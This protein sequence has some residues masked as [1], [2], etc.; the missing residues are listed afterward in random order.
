MY[1]S[2]I[3]KKPFNQTVCISRSSKF[4][5]EQMINHLTCYEA[6]PIGLVAYSL[7]TSNCIMFWG[8]DY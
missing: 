5:L 4:K 6:R 2:T 7:Q 3:S 8:M 1:A